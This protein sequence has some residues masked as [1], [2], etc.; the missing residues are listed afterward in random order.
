MSVQCLCAYI[1]L[2]QERNGSSFN[3]LAVKGKHLFFSH[4]HGTFSLYL[5]LILL[6]DHICHVC[7]DPGA[8]QQSSL[9]PPF[10]GQRGNL[11]P[12]CTT[13]P[14]AKT[15]SDLIWL[16]QLVSLS[17]SKVSSL[18]SNSTQFCLLILLA[19]RAEIPW[20]IIEWRLINLWSVNWQIGGG[21]W[22]TEGSTI[23]EIPEKEKP[24]ISVEI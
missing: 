11:I 10:R 17:I 6:N 5:A 23:V 2:L 4:Q 8:L 13:G 24:D 16:L 9:K 22:Q 12:P 7:P 14:W 15:P 18:D 20:I 21:K 1:V 19:V 3:A